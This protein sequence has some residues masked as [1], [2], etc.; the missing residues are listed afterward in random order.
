MTL[1]VPFSAG[2]TIIN[3]FGGGG[4]DGDDVSSVMRFVEYIPLVNTGSVAVAKRGVPCTEAAGLESTIAA[5]IVI[6]FSARERT[7][8][9]QLKEMNSKGGFQ[10]YI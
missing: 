3:G 5:I 7:V 8:E 10:I 1:K 9:R 6:L 4:E 2:V